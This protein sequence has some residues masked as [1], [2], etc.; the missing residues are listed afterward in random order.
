MGSLAEVQD[1]LDVFSE[2]MKSHEFV[3]LDDVSDQYGTYYE[4]TTG[5][6][7]LGLHY[8]LVEDCWKLSWTHGSMPTNQYVCG[9]GLAAVTMV[10]RILNTAVGNDRVVY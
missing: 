10:V 3:K 8:S 4:S 2:L 1:S 5:V 7:V 9:E 6:D